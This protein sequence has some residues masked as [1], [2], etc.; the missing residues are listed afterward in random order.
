ML[1]WP[2]WPPP[3][4]VK[5]APE[6]RDPGDEH[7]AER[8]GRR[9]G[10]DEDVVVADVGELVSEDAAEL[11]AVEHLEDALRAAHGGV[12]LVA[13]GRERVGLAFR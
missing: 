11:V 3:P 6:H 1:P 12:V 7:D 8:D 4:P 2:S 5:I 9:D 10:A 13:A